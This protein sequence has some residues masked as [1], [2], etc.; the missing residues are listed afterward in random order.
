MK[1]YVFYK[2]NKI[3]LDFNENLST[4]EPIKSLDELE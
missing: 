4:I 3:T 2:S 1:K